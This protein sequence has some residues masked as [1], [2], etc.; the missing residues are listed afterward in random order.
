MSAYLGHCLADGQ[1]HSLGDGH[2]QGHAHGNSHG[3]GHGLCHGYGLGVN[4]GVGLVN[5]QGQGLEVSGIHSVQFSRGTCTHHSVTKGRY[6][7]ASAAKTDVA[8]SFSSCSLVKR[9]AISRS[10]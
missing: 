5:G 3:P 7:A 10:G 9:P 1:G 4:P 6:R 8:T 2:G